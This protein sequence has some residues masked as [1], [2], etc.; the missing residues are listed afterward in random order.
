MIG[1]SSKSW[2]LSSTQE[3]REIAHY[4]LQREHPGHTLQSAALVHEANLRRVAQK[5]FGADNRAHFLAVAS[6]LMREW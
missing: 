2:C 4:H 3:L 1:R 6:R 5:P